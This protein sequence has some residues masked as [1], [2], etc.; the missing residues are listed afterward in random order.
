MD[1]Q[2]K[3]WFKN[4]YILKDYRSSYPDKWPE[5]KEVYKG[6]NIGTWGDSQKRSYKKNNLKGSRKEL[7]DS[8]GFPWDVKFYNWFKE[9]ELLKEFRDEYPDRWPRQKES[10]KGVKIGIWSHQQ[11]SRYHNNKLEKKRIDALN[12]IEFY[13]GKRQ[14]GKK[15]KNELWNSYYNLLKQFRLFNR[16]HW[17]N[18]GEVFNEC[19]I[20]DWCCNQRRLYGAGRLSNDYKVRL[21]E[22][23][24]P[25]N[26]Q[27]ETWLKNF[28]ILKEFYKEYPYRNPKSTEIFKEFELG[29]WCSYLR[30]QVKANSLNSKKMKLLESVDFLSKPL[31]LESVW[32]SYFECLIDFLDKYPNKW[33]KVIQTFNKVKLGRWCYEQRY[34]QSLGKL[35]RSKYDLLNSI[36]FDW[37]S[38]RKK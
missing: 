24:F 8:I 15:E 25:W 34:L 7:L 27:E 21:N 30:S 23:Q 35:S 12:G 17:P 36:G 22:I 20:G 29:I 13:W 32:I 3:A 9:L 33:P 16:D 28:R 19:N 6:E 5:A 10:F 4:F 2:N 26:N 38:N 1:V 18:K 31:H 14:L 11:Q 37:I